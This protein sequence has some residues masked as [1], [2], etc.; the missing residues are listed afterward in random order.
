MTDVKEAVHKAAEI[1][2][3]LYLEAKDI[4][5]EE[6]EHGTSMWSVV[7]S[8]KTEEPTTLAS[9]MGKDS[10]LFKVVNLDPSSGELIS[11]RMMRD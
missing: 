11:L 9:V 10:R 3:D 5:L 2:V 1:V 7:M 4:R 8:F 6:V